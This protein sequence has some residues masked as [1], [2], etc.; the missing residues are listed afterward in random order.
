MVQEKFVKIQGASIHYL[1]VGSQAKPAIFLLHG[2]RFSAQTWQDL[3]TLEILAEQG[4]RAVAIDL[5]GYGQSEQ[6][7]S[8][9]LEFLFDVVRSLK[10]EGS[11]VVS[12]SMSGNYSLPLIAEYPQLFSG[13]VPIAPVGIPAYA[14]KLE[15]IALP[16]LA[17]WGSD[18][19]LVPVHLADE[20]IAGLPNS[21]KVILEGA[22]HPAYLDAPEEFHHQ[23]VAFVQSHVLQD[24]AK[25]QNVEA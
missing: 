23:L 25:A 18:D 6:T 13:F 17:I 16:V 4:W 10:L 7:V 24:V 3:G 19:Q 12:P 9:P 20:L 14:P 2:G 5:P 21:R 1:E 15:G 11:V 8:L 22:G